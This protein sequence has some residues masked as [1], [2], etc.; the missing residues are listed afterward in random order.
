[1]LGYTPDEMRNL[2]VWDWGHALGGTGSSN[3]LRTI[4]E[5][6]DHFRPGTVRRDGSGCGFEISTNAAVFRNRETAILRCPGLRLP[7]NSWKM[8]S[9]WR[10][11]SS[12][13]SPAS[14]G[15]DYQQDLGHPG[16][17]CT[18]EKK[19]D[20]AGSAAVHQ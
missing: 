13:C 19:G 5:T 1:M 10:T 11:G 20:P 7:A 18:R 14:H 2:H 15:I 6:G 8:P 4:N 16:I 9:A 12:T 17:P 3:M